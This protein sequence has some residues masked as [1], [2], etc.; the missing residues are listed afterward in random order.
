MRVLD[1]GC[2]WGGMGLTL[3][4]D[5]GAEVL[6]VTLSEEQLKLARA[7]AE[8][9]GLADRVRFELMD[10]RAVTGQFDRIVS[11]GMFEHV[12]A[13]NF[14]TYFGKVEGTAETRRRGA[15]PRPS[16][17]SPRPA[18]PT[19]GSPATSSRAAISRPCPR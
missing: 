4:R 1:I 7:R 2:G 8:A 15:D 6:G 10:Y 19:P 13:P 9:A 14:R 11:V 3:A 12:G 18:R 17:A 5:H 16:A